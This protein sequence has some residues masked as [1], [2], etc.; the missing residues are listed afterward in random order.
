MKYIF[1]I[2]KEA[3]QIIGVTEKQTEIAI[4]KNFYKNDGSGP[5]W[6][7][8]SQENNSIAFY[9]QIS[10]ERS[11]K[12]R[13]IHI[14]SSQTMLTFFIIIA[15]LRGFIS[16]SLSLASSL[17]FIIGPNNLKDNW[18]ELFKENNFQNPW[19]ILGIFN[20]PSVIDE[21]QLFDTKEQKAKDH[22][23]KVIHI[24]MSEIRSNSQ[25]N[26]EYNT[27]PLSLSAKSFK[28]ENP[29][30]L[31]GCNINEFING[32]KN[33]DVSM[34]IEQWLLTGLISVELF[35]TGQMGKVPHIIKG[36]VLLTDKKRIV[37]LTGATGNVAFV[38]IKHKSGYITL[39]MTDFVNAIDANMKIVL[40]TLD[41]MDKKNTYL[42]TGGSK[43]VM[44]GQF[45]I[46]IQLEGLSLLR[47]FSMVGFNS[48]TFS[49]LNG[50][51]K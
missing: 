41:G 28:I 9:N 10:E 15:K 34:H 37:D 48:T 30:E 42:D 38:S 49:L 1:K 26:Y 8:Y 39:K 35:D 17:Q 6:A 51:C 12:Y 18:D 29:E 43:F 16:L 2:S 25:G 3:G 46:S 11:E 27:R 21:R 14:D 24:R 40:N 19:K 44:N 5:L 32:I 13:I 20:F 22:N 7:I 45:G 50:T 36:N 31:I 23:F 4:T 33:D 47:Q